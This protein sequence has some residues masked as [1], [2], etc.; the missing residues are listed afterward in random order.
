MLGPR[1][2]DARSR[3]V[4]RWDPEVPPPVVKSFHHNYWGCGTSRDFRDVRLPD[5]VHRVSRV[6]QTFV[7]FAN[8]WVLRMA[9]VECSIPSGNPIKVSRKS[10][11][12][13]D[14]TI[15]QLR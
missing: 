14:L 9:V 1:R 10:Q 3:G 2:R 13:C 8:V 6:P 12:W 15:F 4:A 7:H 5:C 11:K